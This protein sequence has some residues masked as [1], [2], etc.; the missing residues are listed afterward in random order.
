MVKIDLTSWIKKIIKFEKHKALSV[1]V[2]LL[3]SILIAILAERGYTF[4]TMIRM[5][6]DG[7]QIITGGFTAINAYRFLLFFSGAFFILI[8]FIIKI[9]IFYDYIYR[10]RYLLAIVIFALL[11]INRIHF[12]S[13][14][15]YNVHIQPGL[16][17]EFS[18]PI[19]G[20]L[21]AIRSDEWLVTTPIQLSAQFEPDPFGHFNQIARGTA[22][23]NMPNGMA[24]N[25][26]T[27]A[28]PM[29]IFYL[30]GVEYGVSARWVGMLIITFMVTFEFAYIISGKSR[31]L[32]LVGACL[33]TFSPFFQWW[34]YV[35]FIP[36]GIGTLVCLYYFINSTGKIKK[37][38]LSLGLTIFFSQ[39]IV[40]LYPAW[41]VPA[42]YLFLGIAVW[43]VADNWEQVKKTDKYGYTVLGLTVVFIAAVVGTYLY[44]S[45]EYITGVSNTLYPGQRIDTGGG[46]FSWNVNRMISG[47]VFAPVSAIR[48]FIYTNVCEFGGMYSLFPIPIIFVSILMIR[49][50]IFDLLSVILITFTFL[51]GSYVF[52]GW[53]EGLARIT[54][55]SFSASARATD[56][57]LLAQMFIFIRVMSR[58]SKPSIE[59]E[60]FIN[61]KK[62]IYSSATAMVLMYFV[63]RFSRSTLET[64]LGFT[65]LMVTTFGITAIIYG[66]YDFQRNKKVFRLA[67]LY[68]IAISA[69]TWITIHPIMRGLDA[70]YSKPLSEKVQELAHDTDEK[71][72]SL[73]GIVGSSFL[74]ANGASTISSANF[75][76]NLE[77][78]HK[79]DPDKH[80]EYEYNRYAVITVGLTHENT[81]FVLRNVDHLHINFSVYDLE[82]AGVKYIHSPVPL[83][84]YND[85]IFTLLYNEGGARVYSVSYQ[86]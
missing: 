2:V 18:E 73:H 84:N 85:I 54:L 3:C 59:N 50:R 19:F 8:H 26:A 45:R 43:I 37:V 78:W 82:T 30:F 24:I 23:E 1:G 46:G 56:V 41:Q 60:E 72:I 6:D 14:G 22:T 52:I 55:M 67:C 4:L 36:A 21:R 29:S 28:F 42:G 68:L 11:V 71:W 39:F 76:P 74:I 13:I 47:G 58:F 48:S 69:T 51:I 10:Y 63:E 38:L 57:M 79:L 66:I 27:L 80:Y 20:L 81:S 12:S 7:T 25:L 33:I 34:S 64:S 83:S 16:G 17:S 40:T 70:I 53:P 65:F 86:G 62:L 77:L 44:A 15:M 61:L 49:K 5:G 75:Y 32:G 31:L 9:E 35:F